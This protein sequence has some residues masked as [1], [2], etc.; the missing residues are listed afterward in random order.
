V[1]T[2]LRPVSPDEPTPRARRGPSTDTGTAT[3]PLGP[4]A[5]EPVTR[6]SQG[7]LASLG[8]RA[9]A[10]ALLLRI[11][12]PALWRV[13][14]HGTVVCLVGAVAVAARLPALPGAGEAE[15][16]QAPSPLSSFAAQMGAGALS[17]LPQPVLGTETG[18]YDGA[19]GE[20][21]TQE[22]GFVSTGPIAEADQSLLPWDEPRRY[23]VEDGDTLSGI[24]AQFGLDPETLLFANPALRA[25]PHNLSIG[26]EVTILP[27]NG[28]LHVVEEGDTLAALAE[29]YGVDESAIVAYGPN[30]L[31][32]G[33][34]LVAGAQ[35]VVPG[36]EMDLSIPSYL[37]LASSSGSSGS[38]GR[39]SG[40]SY[41]GPAVVGTGRFHVATYGRLTQGFRGYHAAVDIAN[42]TGTPIYAI[43]GGTVEVAGW[44]SWAGKAVIINHG[45]GYRSLYAHMS[46][47]NVSAGQNV[48]PGTILGGIGCTRGRGGY[49]SGPHLHLEVTLNG[50]KQNPCGLGACP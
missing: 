35:V 29:S 37:E 43:D 15:P 14:A 50:R 42:R 32:D 40:S 41:S 25:D 44:W 47:I 8:R 26:D 21:E 19:G 39:G 49:C 2:A 48:A 5:T 46:S 30:G 38:A 36:G 7:R 34:A 11:D 9:R 3:E 16:A 1:P 17:L 23:V 4:L 6:A 31:A 13:A 18:V 12:S 22:P 10:V 33:A 45:N 24:A 27:V 20:S 28:V